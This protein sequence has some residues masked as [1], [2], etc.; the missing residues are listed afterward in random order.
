MYQLVSPKTALSQIIFLVILACSTLILKGQSNDTFGK[1]HDYIPDSYILN[2]QNYEAQ[3][4]DADNATFNVTFYQDIDY[5]LVG[6]TNIGD[7]D[8]K[9]T[10]YDQKNNELFTNAP[11]Q[12]SP[13]W[14]FKFKSTT[15]AIVKLELVNTSQ[16]KGKIKLLIGYNP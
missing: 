13:Y 5:R 16:T 7:A 12:Y 10:I 15:E 11:Y 4:N 1:C 6:C 9:M 14:D 8:V 3:L 2:E